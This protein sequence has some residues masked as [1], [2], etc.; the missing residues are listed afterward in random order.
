MKTSRQL[1]R[2][3][4]DDFSR[5]EAAAALRISVSQLDYATRNKELGCY[6][7]GRHVTYGQ[8][9]L[10]A[11]RL[12][13]EQHLSEGIAQRLVANIRKHLE[14]MQALLENVA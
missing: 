11:Y 12:T 4:G 1:P 2:T 6:R 9:H 14:Q 8:G 3:A 7:H 10:D 13:H 5:V